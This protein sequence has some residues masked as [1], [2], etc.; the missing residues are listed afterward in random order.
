MPMTTLT[1]K[2]RLLYRFIQIKTGVVFKIIQLRFFTKTFNF[3]FAYKHKRF[4]VTPAAYS[5][6]FT[7]Y[8]VY[9]NN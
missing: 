8:T 6:Y 1:E 5:K 3:T 4:T 2:C 7:F 9:L